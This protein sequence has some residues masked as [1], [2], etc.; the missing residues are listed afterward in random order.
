MVE[1][2]EPAP[3]FLTFESKP[4]I[5]D[6]IPETKQDRIRFSHAAAANPMSAAKIPVQLQI[7]YDA[8]SRLWVRK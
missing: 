3:H 7:G 8:H 5:R 6:E 2:D 1:S 4:P